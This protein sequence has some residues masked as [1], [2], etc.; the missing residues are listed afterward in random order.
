MVHTHTRKHRTWPSLLYRGWQ[1]R[2]LRELEGRYDTSMVQQQQSEKLKLCG[3][4]CAAWF[5]SVWRNVIPRKRASSRDFGAGA[6]EPGRGPN[7]RRSVHAPPPACPAAESVKHDPRAPVK[8][9]KCP[10][11]NALEQSN[12]YDGGF[13]ATG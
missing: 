2:E 1:S 10:E 7:V 9:V 12:V 8:A 11:R 3:F 4:R 5:G 6:T 13:A